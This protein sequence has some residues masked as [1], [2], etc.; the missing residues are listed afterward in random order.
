[1]LFEKICE[2]P[3]GMQN[4]NKRVFKVYFANYAND[5]FLQGYKI[6]DVN[7]NEYEVYVSRKLNELFDYGVINLK[8]DTNVEQIDGITDVEIANDNVKG[9]AKLL[10]V[11]IVYQEDKDNIKDNSIGL[12]D[13]TDIAVLKQN[14]PA[15]ANYIEMLSFIIKKKYEKI[16][17]TITDTKIREEAIYTLFFNKDID[18]LLYNDFERKMFMEIFPTKQP[19]LLGPMNKF[20]K[21]MKIIRENKLNTVG[22]GFEDILYGMQIIDSLD[23]FYVKEQMKL[24]NVPRKK[25]MSFDFSEDA[26]TL[27]KLF[28][29]F[30]TGFVR[31]KKLSFYMNGKAIVLNAN[32]LAYRETMMFNLNNTKMFSLSFN[33]GYLMVFID[34][35]AINYSDGKIGYASPK[36]MDENFDIVSLEDGILTI[37]I[38]N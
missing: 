5:L 25:T 12:Q 32:V 1:M 31:I 34:K 29:S 35:K 2:I 21:L 6:L 27:L 18:K 38:E 19:L 8:K 4:N 9:F 16:G 15:V 3:Y 36:E 30:I 7:S 20:F 17:E 33:D 10:T 13:S 26:D 37:E 24:I 22:L 28:N 23:E 11:T 14:Q